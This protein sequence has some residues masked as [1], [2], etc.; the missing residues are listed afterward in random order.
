MKTQALEACPFCGGTEIFIEPDERGSGGQWVSPVHVGC[1]ACKC[2]QRGEQQEEAV[3][4]WNHRTVP[5]VREI[6]RFN[7]RADL[8]NPESNGLY[9][10]YEDHLTLP[11]S[12]AAE[13][14]GG[15]QL[16]R[17]V[18]GYAGLGQTAATFEPVVTPAQAGYVTAFYELAA[19]M[20]IPAQ[21]VS[22][23][24]VWQEQMLPK[25]REALAVPAALA[26]VA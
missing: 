7:N 5:K 20:G 8:M 4:A 2:E 12:N 10:R 6:Q 3:A 14:A 25:L 9:V 1:V 21:P 24:K 26:A 13:P 11:A 15:E 22:P 19:L 18:V 23:E 17:R 16:Y